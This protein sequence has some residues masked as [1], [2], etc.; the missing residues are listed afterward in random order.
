[1]SVIWA[2]SAKGSRIRFDKEVSEMVGLIGK[3]LGMTQVY[4]E[5]EELIPVTIVAAGPCPVVHPRLE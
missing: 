4:N 5:R 1:M 2:A 3:K